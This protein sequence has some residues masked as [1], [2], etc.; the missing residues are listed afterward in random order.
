LRPSLP[1]DEVLD[2]LVDHLEA[3]GRNAVLIAPPGAGKTTC[4]PPALL[5]RL[6]EGQI[7]VAQP[8]RLAAR[9]AASTVARWRGQSL[10]EEVGFAVRFESR[11][12]ASTRLLFVTEGV[13]LRR[14]RDDPALD[15]V[16]AILFDEIHER[17]LAGDLALALARRSQREGRPDLRLVAMSATLDPGPLADFLDAPTFESK[18]RAY[19]VEVEYL[20]ARDRPLE[21]QVL[22]A[23]QKRVEAAPS[24]DVDGLGHVLVFLPGA[25]EIRRCAS[26]LAGFCDHHGLV[27]R[28]LHA[29]LPPDEQDL[30]VAPSG[31]PKVILSTNVAETSLTIDQVATVIDSGLARVARHD[32][33]AGLPRLE[34]QPVSRASGIQR[35]GRAGRTREGHCIRLYGQADFERR[36]TREQPEVLRTDLADAVFDLALA[37]V[38][39]PASFD[40]FETPP[41]AASSEALTLLRRLEALDDAG[42]PTPLGR[43]MAPLPLHPRLACAWA[44]AVEAGVG[45]L[46]CSVVA[47][48]AE[49][50]LRRSD[51]VPEHHDLADPLYE[52]ERLRRTRR[53]PHRRARQGIDPRAATAVERAQRALQNCL[54]GRSQYKDRLRGETANQALAR[55]LLPAFVDRLGRLRQRKD[56]LELLG[57]DGRAIALSPSCVVRDA[58]FAV[59]LR[60]ESRQRGTHRIEEITA[61]CAIS[62]DDILELC[63]DELDEIE[64]VDFDRKRERVVA[65]RE[66]RLDALVLEREE[67]STLP[68]GASERLFEEAKSAGIERFVDAEALGQLRH[69][70]RFVREHLDESF[71]ELDQERLESSLR[72]LCEGRRSFAQLREGDLIACVRG[73]LGPQLASLDRLAPAQVTLPGGRRLKVDYTPGQPPSVASFLQDFF[74]SSRG[75]TIGEGRIDLTLHLRAPNRRDVQV[76]R[77]LAGFWERHYPSLAKQLKRRYPKHDWPDD[78]VHAEP[79]KPRPRRPRKKKR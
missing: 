40:W 13:L 44:H 54:P 67:L 72:Q 77:D 25:A 61:A 52:L 34:L 74:G 55:A 71:P 32:P 23:L 31:I 10:G 11:S 14:L 3:P 43:A 68:E 48:L 41:A 69:R 28:P 8:R 7:I 70:L 35:A 63:M 59:A 65:V 46:A 47:I 19:P 15:G 66:L 1:I 30:A 57:R 38:A 17:H 2:E 37:G 51:V 73:K 12:S 20:V 49:R 5:E 33:H 39:D 27:L 53:E 21:A 50:R 79:P 56:T 75:P 76:T 78:P 26:K 4:V 62:E 58:T 60:A 22:R 18:G 45:R 6:G 24:V 16:S 42:A 36:P 29:S 9:M 64:I